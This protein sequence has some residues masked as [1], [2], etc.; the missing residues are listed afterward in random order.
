MLQTA[1]Q[2][3]RMEEPMQ[4]PD[5]TQLLTPVLTSLQGAIPIFAVI[6]L[7]WVVYEEWTRNPGSF[8][9][10]SAFWKCLAIGLIAFFL[11]NAQ[12]IIES[13]SGAGGT[14]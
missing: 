14:P 6:I 12:T 10:F 11:M 4:F 3:E 1:T 9:W 13:I 5:L 2:L 7:I 8:S